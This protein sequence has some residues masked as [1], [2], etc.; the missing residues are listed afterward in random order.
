MREMPAASEKPVL[1]PTMGVFMI[2]LFGSYLAG[3]AVASFLLML[4]TIP[5]EGLGQLVGIPLLMLVSFIFSLPFLVVAVLL[6]LA[7]KDN[8]FRHLLAWCVGAS[9]VVPVLSV[10]IV[11]W[12]NFKSE[13]WNFALRVKD[14]VGIMAFL[15]TPVYMAI[16]YQWNRIAERRARFPGLQSAAP[17]NEDR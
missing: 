13:G 6:A 10:L 2:R 16:F 9:V 7:F 11:Y 12:P 8:M 17:G 15:Y 5:R 4:P 14:Y 3:S 1:P